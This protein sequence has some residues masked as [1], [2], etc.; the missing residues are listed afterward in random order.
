M[1]HPA[2]A[3]LEA[4]LA[5]L[6]AARIEHIVVGGAAAVLHGAPITTQDLDVVYRRTADN[7]DRLEALLGDLDAFARDPAGRKLRPNRS[8]LEAGGVLLLTTRLGPFDPMAKL[9]DGRGF[10]ELLAHSVMVE[11]EG[12]ALRVLDLPTLIEVKAAA[13][14]AKDRLVLP[15]LLALLEPD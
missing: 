3:D 12:L 15:V 11:D 8:H 2:S 4:L 7:L 1:P 14:R 9:A 5:A 10:E 6:A 13:N